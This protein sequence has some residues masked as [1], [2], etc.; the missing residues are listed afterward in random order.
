MVHILC[1]H[2]GVEVLLV[3]KHVNISF[4]LVDLSLELG[5]GVVLLLFFAIDIVSH[6]LVDHFS[7]NFREDNGAVDFGLQFDG[8]VGGLVVFIVPAILEV[9]PAH[10]FIGIRRISTD[11]LL[12]LNCNEHIT[13][14]H[15]KNLNDL[16]LKLPS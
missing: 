8:E 13:L 7:S 14:N 15:P 3:L 2:A 11:S 4:E 16:S 10:N 1:P 6:F 9:S 5:D 12:F